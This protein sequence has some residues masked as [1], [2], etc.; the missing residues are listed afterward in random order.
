PTWED[1][2]AI[3]LAERPP[4][5]PQPPPQPAAHQHQDPPHIPHQHQYSDFEPGMVASM[6]DQYYRMD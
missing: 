6:Y 5:P 3:A 2:D 4:Q 1:T